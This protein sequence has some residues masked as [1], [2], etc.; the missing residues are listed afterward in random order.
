MGINNSKRFILLLV[1]LLTGGIVGGCIWL[2]LKIISAGT[3]FIWNFIPQNVHIPYYTL[4]VCLVGGVILGLLQM[5]FGPLPDELDTVMAK[6]KKDKFYPYNNLH[7]V[8]VCA[9]IPLIFGGSIGPEAGLTGVIVG[10][11]YW[12]STKLKRVRMDLSDLASIG[13]ATTLGIIFGEPL[14]GIVQPI[15]K[16]TDSDEEALWPKSTKMATYIIAAFAGFGVYILLSNFFGGGLGLPRFSRGSTGKSEL[17]FAIPIALIGC[18]GGYL[19]C[20]FNK[21]TEKFFSKFQTKKLRFVSCIIGAVCLGIMGTL[22]PL[23]MFSGEQQIETLQNHYLSYAPYILILS[24]I[25]KLLLTNICIKSGW[26]GGHFFPV[27]FC[28]VSI[29]YGVSMLLNT[30]IVFTVAVLSASLLGTTMRKPLAVT[31]L[32]ILCFPIT[33]VPW[34]LVSAYLGSIVPLPKFLQQK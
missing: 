1:S 3:S 8:A 21:G 31:A 5:Q 20:L 7:L 6:V 34:M 27:I 18:I 4:I 14:F 23:T 22:L 9:V 10:L 24:G 28:G 29:G 2:I 15:E 17:F 13:V 16:T 11:C 32:L 26:R 33:I 12:L 25:V 30:D 19:F